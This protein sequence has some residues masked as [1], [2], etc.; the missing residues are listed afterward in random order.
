[1]KSIEFTVSGPTVLQFMSQ[2]N[3]SKRWFL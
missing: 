2:A 1:M 3:Y